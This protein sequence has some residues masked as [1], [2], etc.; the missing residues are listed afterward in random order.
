MLDR[1]DGVPMPVTLPSFLTCAGPVSHGTLDLGLAT[2][3]APALYDF[4]V[5]QG[6]PCEPPGLPVETVVV[7]S[8]AG[9]WSAGGNRVTFRSKDAARIGEYKG[10]TRPVGTGGG[11]GP[12]L[13]FSVDRHSYTWRRVRGETTSYGSLRVSVLDEQARFV[14]GAKLE[15]RESDGLVSN[16]TTNNDRPFGTGVPVGLSVTIHIRLPAGYALAT[17]QSNPVT[18]VAGQTSIVTIRAVKISP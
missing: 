6:R 12:V 7:A 18:V 1:L 11:L 15:F 5:Y 3:E 4:Q 16:A 13:E 9:Y 10:A 14:N 2:S 17:S 8:D